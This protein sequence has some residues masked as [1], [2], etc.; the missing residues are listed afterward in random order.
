M[1]YVLFA[2]HAGEA[3]VFNL[4]R[5][6]TFRSAGAVVTALAVSFVLGPHIIRWLKKK[7]RDGQPIRIDGPE[8]HLLT[9]KGTP[10]MGGVLILLALAISTLL[11]ADLRDR[12]VWVVL[13]VTVGF[14][15][16]GFADDYLKLTRRNSKGLPGRRKLI[17]QIVI[18]V[19]AAWAIARLSPTP[20][21]DRL[22]VPFFKELLI[23]L[24]WFYIRS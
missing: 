9:K 14:G 2:P 10:T 8:S 3:L 13:F 15:A 11:W 20:L 19:V 4:F 22:A 18:A 21:D 7:Q 1:L 12:F 23:H 6:L 5:Y 17:G 16:I 24:G